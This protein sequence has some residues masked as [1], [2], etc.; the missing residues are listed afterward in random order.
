MTFINNRSIV[1]SATVLI[2]GLLAGCSFSSDSLLPSLTGEDPA[3]SSSTTQAQSRAPVQQSTPTRAQQPVR[4]AQPPA[5]GTTKFE[6]KGVTSGSNTGTFVGQK[7]IELRAELRRLQANVSKNNGELQSVRGKTVQDSQRYHTAISAINA[8][9]QVGTTPGNPVLVGQF[10]QA[11][12]DLKKI[13]DDISDMN[14]LTTNVTADSTLAAFLAENTRAAFRL[15]GA[16]DTDHQQLSILEDEVN[17]TVVLIDRL[18]KELTEDIQRQTNYVATERSNL[19]TLSAAVKS[20]ELMGASLTNRALTAATAGTTNRRAQSRSLVGRRPLVVI[21]FDRSNVAYDQALY[22][23]VSRTL[24][25]RPSA[26][27]ELVAV[28]P[29]SGGAARVALNSNKARRNAESVMRSLQ[30]MGLPPQRIAVS[31]RTSQAAQSN[32]VHLYLN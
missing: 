31:A 7:A 3:G 28:A 22:S 27:F 2:T 14:V 13:G 18:L 15:S 25:R 20:G 32:E 21:R 29:A 8:R 16:I 6:P 4:A 10:N 5:M 11:L 19:N 26:T 30:R 17:R 1:V 24:E 9:L 12:S 23:A